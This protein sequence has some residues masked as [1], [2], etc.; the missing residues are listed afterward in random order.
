MVVNHIVIVNQEVNLVCA[1]EAFYFEQKS[2]AHFE[3]HLAIQFIIHFTK[4]MEAYQAEEEGDA[5]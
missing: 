1:E 4:L 2:S 3:P 5:E